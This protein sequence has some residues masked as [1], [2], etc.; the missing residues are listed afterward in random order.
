[1]PSESQ[2]SRL[3]LFAQGELNLPA[4]ALAAYD[5]NGI[6]F[7][8][9]LNN[10]QRINLYDTKNFDKEPFLHIVLEDPS[11]N[12]ISFPPRKPVMTSLAFSA[13]GKYLLVGTAGDAHYVLDAFEGTLLYK[14]E[15][16]IG[17]ERGKTGMHVGMVPE[18]GI[19]GGEVCWTPDSR[20]ICGG[21]QDGRV[22]IWDLSDP[23]NLP[24]PSPP[25][26]DPA[27]LKPVFSL[28]GHPGASRCVRFNPRFMMLVTAGSELVRFPE[29]HHHY[30]M[31]TSH[32]G[33]LASRSGQF[34][35]G[36]NED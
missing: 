32:L 2:I 31:L 17:L 30:P 8:V 35:W 29:P 6:I 28:E 16:F 26:T 9:A 12:K 20:F 25:G 24:S 15:G 27:V 19:S 13:N 34:R 36:Y 33:V 3:H 11:L 21:S 4:S 23:E 1:M 10:Y 14:L 18:R 7:A 5:A 22:H